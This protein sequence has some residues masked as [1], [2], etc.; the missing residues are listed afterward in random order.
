MNAEQV[1]KKILSEANE[2]AQAI[3][4]QAAQ[5]R[6]Q[7][8]RQLDEE[9]TAYRAETERLACEAAEDRQARMLAAARMDNSRAMLAAKVELLDEAFRK[10]QER[11]VQL[12]DEQY[13]AL[14]TTLMKQAVQT[15][16][17]EVVVAKGERRITDE[18][19]KQIN[20]QLGTGFKGNLRL[21]DKHADI[22]GGFLLARGKVQMNASVEVLVD[23]LRETMET[24]LAAK[25]FAD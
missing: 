2:Q 9:L 5:K 23:R 19:V 20:R 13:K 15:G 21:S 8:L 25:L 24:E 11:I 6:D 14:M 22:K 3:A 12:P 7:Q 18:F 1:V 16:D 10:A 17:E 4:Q